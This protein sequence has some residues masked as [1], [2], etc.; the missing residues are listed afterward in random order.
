MAIPVVQLGTG[1][2]GD[3][4]AASAYHQP[5]VRAHRRLGVIG[6]QGR[7]GRGRACRTC[8]FDR[9]AGQH[10]P[11]RRAC[12]RAAMRGLQRDGRQPAARGAGGLPACPG[13]RDQHRRQRPGLSAV[14]VAGDPRGARSTRWKTLRAKAIRACTSTA[15]IPASPTTCCRWHWP[16]PV[17]ASSRF[18]AWR[19]STTPP[20]TAPRSCST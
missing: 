14:S 7:Q 6:L 9:R 10:R 13:G 12:H 16:A 11:G 19:S 2:V 15:S 20:T 1:N 4:R 8:G 18:G 5:R 3:P 17:R